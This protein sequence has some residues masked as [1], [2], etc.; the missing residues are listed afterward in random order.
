VPTYTNPIYPYQK[1][2]ELAGAKAQRRPVV[3]VGAG[4]VGLS[5]AIDL[6]QQDIPVLVLDE[7]ETVSTGSRAIC[8]S[9]R[10][11]EIW[12]RLGVA[13]PMVNKGVTWDTGKLYVGDKL[14]YSF[15]MTPEAHQQFPAF[16]NLQQYYVEEYLVER[17]AELPDIELR[18]KNKVVGVQ[19]GR[20]EVVLDVETQDGSYQIAAQYVIAADGVRST[21]RS[22][23]GLGFPGQVFNDRFLIADVHMK[24]SFPSERWFWFDPPFHRHQSALLH[25]QADDVWRIDFQLGV[26]A[27][28]EWE[29]KVEA[30]TP[31]LKAMLGETATF[32]YEWIS[33]YSFTCRC[34]EKFTHGRVLFAGDAAHVVSP[35]GARG[36]NSG[37]AD[38]DNLVWKLALV[39]RGQASPAL[40]ES[41]SQERVQ[42]ALENQRHSTRSTDFITP[43]NDASRTLRDAVLS[44]APDFPFARALVNSGRLSTPTTYRGSPLVTPDEDP[45]D[46][47]GTTSPGAPAV[48]GPVASGGDL[49]WLLERLGGRFTLM[50]FAERADEI[51]LRMVAACEAMAGPVKLAPLLITRRGASSDVA[52]PVAEDSENVL[53]QR[54]DAKRGTVYLIRPDQHVAA[55]WREFDRGKV[56]LALRRAVAAE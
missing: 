1:P 48:D 4:P 25:R 8:W 53:W 39:L 9:K 56:A 12:D 19:S 18:W 32:D 14:A 7:D 42:A 41:Y 3:I 21:I 2:A 50:V 15:A 27:D 43:K 30:V 44:L 11:L 34:M 31:R 33:V 38:A 23:L 5:A 13:T 28:P 40:L 26:D 36:G 47:S 52:W 49:G 35:F 46:W 20:D 55:R 37:V 29:G 24:A 51:D 45:E 22:A 17:C 10:T 6:A 54:Y 16:I